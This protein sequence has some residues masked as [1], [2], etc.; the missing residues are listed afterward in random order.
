MCSSSSNSRSPFLR[1]V[2]VVLCLLADE[3]SGATLGTMFSHGKKE[4][5]GSFAETMDVM[6]N[7]PAGISIPSSVIALL[8]TDDASRY[9]QM[10]RPRNLTAD[11]HIN[12][13]RSP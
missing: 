1:C 2:L 11:L 10:I 9:Q 4:Y 5:R 13:L 12:S 3:G 8:F 7:S 6:G